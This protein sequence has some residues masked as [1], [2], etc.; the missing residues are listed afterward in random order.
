MQ[1][2]KPKKPS[3]FPSLVKFKLFIARFHMRMFQF[4]LLS[5]I[6]KMKTEYYSFLL[7]FMLKLLFFC[8]KQLYL[9][10]S[11]QKTKCYVELIVYF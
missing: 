8:Q 6:S 2:D 1:V 10:Y 5:G 4:V 11:E 7:H 9:K 3:S